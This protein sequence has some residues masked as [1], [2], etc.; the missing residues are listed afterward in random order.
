MAFNYSVMPHRP[1]GGVWTSA[2]DLIRYV[3]LELARGKLPG[4]KQLVSEENILARRLPQIATGESQSYGMGL[5]VD[6]TWGATVVHHGGSMAETEEERA[7][8]MAAWGAWFGGLGSAI[9]DPGNPVGQ[10]VTIAVDGSTSDGG[11][12]NPVSG[13][14][15]I[16]AADLAS[17][18]TSAK[19]C[20]VLQGGGS[21]EVCETFE[22]M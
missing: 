8:V 1:A 4:G 16:E 3:Q 10:A 12:A 21:I 11:G 22:V 5:S 18:V 20:P 15:I 13:Y 2:H 19:A 14:S 17:A 7:Q 6:K 9:A